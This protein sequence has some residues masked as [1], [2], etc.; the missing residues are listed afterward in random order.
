MLIP[1]A[2]ASASD[3]YREKCAL[4]HDSG[5][6]SAPRAGRPADWAQRA[7]KGYAGLLRSALQ[8][9]PGTAMLPRAGFPELREEEVGEAVRYLLASVNL[10]PDLPA[11]ASAAAP[12]APAPR[13]A[14]SIVPV[15]DVTLAVAVADA[16]VSARI[17]G[18]QVESR[19]G[20][21]TLKG[22]V[23]DKAS[24]ERALKAAQSVA[25]VRD[26]DNR[27]VPADVFEHD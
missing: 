25:G 7:D 4:C 16:L 12:A 1:A 8:G 9:V 10:P 17:G 24:A 11:K 20:R 15:D 14:V 2:L 22:V 18:V 19:S 23:N 21:I 26:I 3:V 5:A 6:T 13:R 27:L